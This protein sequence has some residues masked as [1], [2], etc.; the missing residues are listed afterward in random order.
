MP[1]Q[2]RSPRRPPVLRPPLPA[3]CAGSSP[4]RWGLVLPGPPR[5]CRV[6]GAAL[7]G[8]GSPPRRCRAGRAARD[9]GEPSPVLQGC[10]VNS[11]EHLRVPYNLQPSKAAP[12]DLRSRLC[13]QNIAESNRK[14]K[15]K[16]PEL[17]HSRKREKLPK[18]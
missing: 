9:L 8:L 7:E 17:R 15:S 12:E 13:R 6:G 1:K 2:S 10:G 16:H 11:H 4:P 14:M 18:Q 5:R 3:P